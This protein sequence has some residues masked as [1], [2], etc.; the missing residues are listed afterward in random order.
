[1]PATWSFPSHV[2]REEDV[3]K[4]QRIHISRYE[5]DLSIRVD[6]IRVPMFGGGTLKRIGFDINPL[7]EKGG[8]PESRLHL[9]FEITDA[10][11]DGPSSHL[12][13]E[14]LHQHLDRDFQPTTDSLCACRVSFDHERGTEEG[15]YRVP[16]NLPRC[17]FSDYV[18]ELL[19]QVVVAWEI[20][21]RSSPGLHV[22][23]E[24]MVKVRDGLFPWV[25]FGEYLEMRERGEL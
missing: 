12:A 8:H 18:V 17:N 16:L 11:I 9:R 15:T 2:Q 4:I 23:R 19:S 21:W 20:N 1:M 6:L 25:G 10:S 3:R 24:T 14:R 22:T 5:W 13:I 7:Y